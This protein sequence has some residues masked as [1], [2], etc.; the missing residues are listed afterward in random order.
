MER[1]AAPTSMRCCSGYSML[2]TL[3][4]E[5]GGYILP[6]LGSAYDTRTVSLG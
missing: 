5:L 6:S 1:G 3:L 2:T 4:L